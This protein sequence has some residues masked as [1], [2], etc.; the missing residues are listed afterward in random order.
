MTGVAAALAAWSTANFS[1]STAGADPSR[2]LR[3]AIERAAE[4][5]AQ[6]GTAAAARRLAE[7]AAQLT[8]VAETLA[9]DALLSLAYAVDLGDPEGAVLNAG[10][11]SHR[12]DFGLG[13]DGAGD[14]SR[15]AWSMPRQEVAPGVPWHVRGSALGLDAA[16]APL[17]L[18]RVDMTRV[19]DAPRLTSNERQTFALSVALLNPF[20]MT[21][22]DRDA[23][24]DAIARGGQRIRLMTAESLDAVARD[25]RLDGWRRRALQWSLLNDPVE[26][27]RLF[28]LTERLYLGGSPPPAVMDGWGMA[29]VVSHGCVCTRLAAPA[30]RWNLSGRPQLG[31]ISTAVPDVHLR[32]AIVL[33]ELG[34]PAGIARHVLSAAVQD[35]VDEVRPNDTDDWLTLVR[36]GQMIS[37]ERIE[38]YVAAVTADGPLIPE[39][40][41]AP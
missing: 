29:A 10:N 21:D 7:V 14:P 9:A 40:R 39:L 12:H 37:R 22:A 25:V 38:D 24:T 23:L 8:P 19:S 34:L 5:L 2:E 1:A 11:V 15:V 16:L 35:Y 30:E 6:P 17:G 26:V 33:R 4:E 32:V 13:A 20:G 41:P 3:A 31:L 27:P 28:S 36:T 18:R